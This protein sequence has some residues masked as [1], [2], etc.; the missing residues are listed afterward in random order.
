[1]PGRWR[2]LDVPG[3]AAACCA[4]FDSLADEVGIDVSKVN[5]H[6]STGLVVRNAPLVDGPPDPPVLLLPSTTQG[7]ALRKDLGDSAEPASSTDRVAVHS[8]FTLAVLCRHAVSEYTPSSKNQRK[9]LWKSPYPHIPYC[10]GSPRSSYPLEPHLWQIYSHGDRFEGEAP[11]GGS[12]A[13]PPCGGRNR[14]VLSGAV[15]NQEK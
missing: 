5:Q 4:G 10:K 1:M 2:S 3:L 15:K 6:S 13:E 12:L 8:R 14:P 7:R 9:H 11:Q